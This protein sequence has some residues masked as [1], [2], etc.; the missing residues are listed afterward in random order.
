MSYLTTAAC[1]VNSLFPQSAGGQ[2]FGI[3]ASAQRPTDFHLLNVAASNP[4]QVR[5]STVTFHTFANQLVTMQ[6][7]LAIPTVEAVNGPYLRERVRFGTIPSGYGDAVSF[8]YTD[9]RHVMSVMASLGYAGQQRP[10]ADRCLISA[11]SLDG[12]IRL[13]TRPG[14]RNLACLSRRIQ[15]PGAMHR[16]TAHLHG[17]GERNAAVAA[18]ARLRPWFSARP[19]WRL[20]PARAPRAAA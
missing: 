20:V 16:G 6:P 19:W 13:H 15:W 5:T 3:P 18:E 14:V 10:R 12:R 4:R 2:L 7:A 9:G 1:T 17:D 11:R 8:R